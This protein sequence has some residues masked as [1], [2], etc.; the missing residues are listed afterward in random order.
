[1]R[2]F[3]QNQTRVKELSHNLRVA[4]VE[5]TSL[6]QAASTVGR[7]RLNLGC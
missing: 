4:M 5:N 3:V 1:M 7:L 6:K 2:G